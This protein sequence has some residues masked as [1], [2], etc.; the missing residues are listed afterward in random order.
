MRI[1]ISW[2]KD[3]VNI[4]LEAPDALNDYAAKMTMS[5][6]KVEKIHRLGADISGVVVGRIEEIYQHPNADKLFVTKVDIGDGE[7]RQIVTGADNLK[8]GDY[9]PVA[10]N[11]AQLANGL[12]IKKTKMRGEVSDGML[13]SIEEVGYTRAEYPEAPEGGIYVFDRP[14]ELGIDARP[15]LGI[16]D[17]VIEFEL[18]TN[19]PDCFSV[20]G[21]ARET[22]AVYGTAYSRYFSRLQP[23]SPPES[24]LNFKKIL[25]RVWDMVYYCWS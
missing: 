21:M 23:T 4:D 18:T 20:I 24:G 3:Y 13:V 12:V 9:I 1:P 15:I 16:L 25:D 17:D 2:L 19:R 14:H 11:G 22:A 7:L 10:V 6:S 5:G 8:K